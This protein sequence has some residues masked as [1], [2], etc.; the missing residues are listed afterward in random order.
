MIGYAMLGTAD[1]ARALRFYEPLM[2]ALDMQPCWRDERSVSWGRENDKRV[3]R[4]FIGLPFDGRPASAGNGTMIAFQL[5]T[6]GQVDR[7]YA[8]AMAHGGSD[9]G[10]PGL[11]PQYGP[12]FYV[13]YVRDP[14]G[15][16]LAFACYDADPAR[17]ENR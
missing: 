17:Q 1:L 9:E 11:R 13:A 3:P 4:F 8:A 7:A 2:Q 5:P 6:T 12:T 10:A 14:D 15:N 16:K